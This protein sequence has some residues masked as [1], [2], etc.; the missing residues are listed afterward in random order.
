MHIDKNY[1]E[2]AITNC[3]LPIC[4]HD[5]PES[6]DV[7]IQQTSGYW[8]TV[9][10]PCDIPVHLSLALHEWFATQPMPDFVIN[11]GDDPAHDIWKQSRQHNIDA[12]ETVVAHHKL[13]FNGTRV[14]PAIG[15]HEQ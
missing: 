13:A 14:Y 5:Q 7:F 9:G 2:N 11:T 6:D 8:G 10:V 4:C 3:G 1:K 15:N 12:M